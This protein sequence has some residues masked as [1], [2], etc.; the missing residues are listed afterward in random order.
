[1][2]RGDNWEITS[3]SSGLPGDDGQ[4]IQFSVPVPSKGEATITYSVHYTW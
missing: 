4:T 2:Y 1:M 3:K